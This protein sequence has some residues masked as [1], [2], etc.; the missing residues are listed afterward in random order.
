MVYFCFSL[1]IGAYQP[2]RISARTVIQ[3]NFIGFFHFYLHTYI[4]SV[5]FSGDSL[6]P[7]RRCHDVLLSMLNE[8]L[9]LSIN[10]SVHSAAQRW[11]AGQKHKRLPELCSR[12]SLRR[13]SSFVVCSGKR[14]STAHF[15]QRKNKSGIQFEH[16]SLFFNC[17]W[18]RIK[19]HSNLS[20]MQRRSAASR[21]ITRSL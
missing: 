8:Q 6:F 10:F 15:N 2:R 1:I 3:S 7:G 12:T 17:G 20:K 5:K 4:T 19:S 13:V 16:F 9:T 14:C 21:L 11:K 18:S